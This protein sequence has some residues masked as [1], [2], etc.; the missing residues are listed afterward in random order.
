MNRRGS[1]GIGDGY[2]KVMCFKNWS[3]TGG[4]GAPEPEPHAPTFC[5]LPGAY[6]GARGARVHSNLL[7]DCGQGG[8]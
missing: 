7:M 6:P 8:A 2:E 5:H 1:G 4:G 3:Q